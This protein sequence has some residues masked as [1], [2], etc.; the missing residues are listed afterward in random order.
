[1]TGNRRFIYFFASIGVSGRWRRRDLG[2]VEGWHKTSGHGRRDVKD[3]RSRQARSLFGHRAGGSPLGF[4]ARGWAGIVVANI[5]CKTE[6][7]AEMEKWE[8][9][10]EG[11]G[12]LSPERQPGALTP[13]AITSSIQSAGTSA[14]GCGQTRTTLLGLA[15]LSDSHL[16]C[17]QLNSRTSPGSV[18]R[19]LRRPRRMESRA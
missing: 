8:S 3:C 6:E 12:Q 14:Q 19:R 7:D 13:Y 5:L 15:L 17:R 10:S 11:I 4:G 9:A 16:R 1:M 18:G 2:R